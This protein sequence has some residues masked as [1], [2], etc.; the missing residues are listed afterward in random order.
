MDLSSPPPLDRFADTP[1]QCSR[2]TYFATQFVTLW[3]PYTCELLQSLPLPSPYEDIKFI[4]FLGA[5]PFL[6]VASFDF[7]YIW[8][9]L[10]L[11]SLCF[12]FLSLIYFCIVF[13]DLVRYLI[14]IHCSVVVWSVQVYAKRLCVDKF[15]SERFAFLTQTPDVCIL[16]IDSHSF[17]PVLARGKTPHCCLLAKVGQ[18]YQNSRRPNWSLGHCICPKLDWWHEGCIPLELEFR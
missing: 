5:S 12:I 2:L 18:A 9:L 8:N 7:I 11:T 16:A 13:Y 6:L 1:F 17:T 15:G 4:G 10:M 3:S 14:K